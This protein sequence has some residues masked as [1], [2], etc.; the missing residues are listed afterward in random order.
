MQ[1]LW[2][3]LTEEMDLGCGAYNPQ[4]GDMVMRR[5]VG[6]T[7]QV[8]AYAT[9]CGDYFASCCYSDV[10]G[11]HGNDTHATLE[12]AQAACVAYDERF[13]L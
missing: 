8:R 6:T 9:K 7:Y 13:A 12:A 11:W 4:A 10:D 3:V 5:D 1:Y 2:S